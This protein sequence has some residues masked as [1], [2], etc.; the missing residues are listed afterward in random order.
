MEQEPQVCIFLSVLWK[1]LVAVSEFPS[2]ISGAGC[3]LIA[4]LPRERPAGERDT[5]SLLAALIWFPG[6]D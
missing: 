4:H 3:Q 6:P 2:A 1:E 5:G